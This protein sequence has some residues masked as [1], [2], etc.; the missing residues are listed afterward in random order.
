M[1]T[2]MGQ[3]VKS[4]NGLWRKY[5]DAEQRNPHVEVLQQCRMWDFRPFFPALKKQ[6]YT[7]CFSHLVRVTTTYSGCIKNIP[8]CTSCVILGKSFT[9]CSGPSATIRNGSNGNKIVYYL[10]LHGA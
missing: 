1:E 10:H 8:N 2:S 6:D 5:E 7:T 9:H 3:R 4:T